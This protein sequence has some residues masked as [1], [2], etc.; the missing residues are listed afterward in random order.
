MNAASAV[1]CATDREQ[2]F[3]DENRK[4]EE[5]SP[6]ERQTNTHTHTHSNTSH[7]DET[8]GSTLHWTGALTLTPATIEP[9]NNKLHLGQARGLS[10][11]ELSGFMAARRKPTYEDRRYA[12]DVCTW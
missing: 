7:T 12:E 9:D 6:V 10:T 2:T 1:R 11:I 4:I 3:Q 5:E 8:T